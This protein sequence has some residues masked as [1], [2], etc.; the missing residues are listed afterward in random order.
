MI[1]DPDK[2]LKELIL[3][4]KKEKEIDTSLSFKTVFEIKE[5]K[6]ILFNKGFLEAEKQAVNVSIEEFGVDVKKEK[7][8]NTPLSMIAGYRYGNSLDIPSFENSIYSL[9]IELPQE[10][11]IKEENVIIKGDINR[12]TKSGKAIESVTEEYIRG[13]G[14]YK[15][16]INGAIYESKKYS[17]ITKSENEIAVDQ[18]SLKS[19]K[20]TDIIISGGGVFTQYL[21][22]LPLLGLSSMFSKGG[23]GTSAVFNYGKSIE[24]QINPI[25]NKQIE[26]V[27]ASLWGKKGKKPPSKSLSEWLALGNE[28]V[29]AITSLASGD[30]SKIVNSIGSIAGTGVSIIKGYKAGKLNLL[31]G[32]LGRYDLKIQDKVLSEMLEISK[33]GTVLKTKG[34][35]LT[36]SA[37]STIAEELSKEN[38]KEFFIEDKET[39]EKIEAEKERKIIIDSIGISENKK[40]LYAKKH[41]TD[42]LETLEEKN[43]KEEKAI[44]LGLVSESS[45]K[46]E[47]EIKVDDSSTKN[48]K[49]EKAIPLGLVSE[50]SGKTEKEIKVDDSSTENK[51]SSLFSK[52]FING[53]KLA[54]HEK[55]R[56]LDE[57]LERRSNQEKIEELGFIYVTPAFSEIL[58]N[59]ANFYKIPIQNNLEIQGD[60]LVAEYNKIDFLNRVGSVVQF[61]RTESRTIEI[62]TEY[63][64]ISDSVFNM[65][66]LQEIEYMYKSLLLPQNISKGDEYYTSRPPIVNISYGF[67]YDKIENKNEEID[68]LNKSLNLTK[69]DKVIN[70]FFTNIRWSQAGTGE[71]RKI[72]DDGEMFY[73][74]FVVTNLTIDKNSETMPM[75]M[76]EENKTGVYKPKDYLGFKI[77]MSLLEID[78]NYLGINPMMNDYYNFSH[79]NY[80]VSREMVNENIETQ[81]S[82]VSGATNPNE[83]FL[84]SP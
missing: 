36:E 83:Q 79:R 84:I 61:V 67:G 23:V 78:P 3:S 8:I 59:K 55:G 60:S 28:G 7:E 80:I 75:Y 43:V 26:N 51:K 65:E 57:L 32:N 49:E 56:I 68:T 66:K 44:P 6:D 74:S 48:V 58:V 38:R 30:V 16:L 40:S 62:V 9:S 46:T 76:V 20:E 69:D 19:L 27:F 47:K 73:R 5:E 50:S 18:S 35:N 24:F 54:D 15:D 71:S 77:T 31:E 4:I 11:D 1:Y 25:S 82:V 13:S 70:N 29:S 10:F 53:K 72:R 63:I 22:K 52:V 33:V 21:D 45:G 37:L 2:E 41:G 42:L 64:A 34:V 39:E 14:I 12:L 81:E 17:D